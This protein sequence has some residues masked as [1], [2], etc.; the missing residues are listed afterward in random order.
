MKGKA[1][2]EQLLL[3]VVQAL[4]RARLEETIRLME[5]RLLSRPAEDLFETRPGSNGA[6]ECHFK[7][8]VE[9]LLHHMRAVATDGGRPPN[10]RHAEIARVMQLAGF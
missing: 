1:A 3:D 2:V 8:M 6:V 10:A 4:G 7:P 5:H 9:L